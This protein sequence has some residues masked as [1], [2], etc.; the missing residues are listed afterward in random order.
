M[1]GC[2]SPSSTILSAV[3]NPIPAKPIITS[4]SPICEGATLT[5]TT[6]NVTGGTFS[7]TGVNSFSTSVQNPSIA[8]ITTA[9]S[10]DY[11]ATVTVDGCTSAASD[12]ISVVVNAK[13]TITASANKTSIC[14]GESVTLT[15]SGAGSSGTYAWDDGSTS[16]LIS[17]S[18][19]SS[20]T[21]SV[22][23]TD[24]NGCT[25]SS[26]VSITVNAIP[27][28]TII[29]NAVCAGNPLS[30]AVT[31]A[32]GGI[33]DYNYIWTVPAGAVAQGSVSSFSTTVPGIYTG[34][35]KDKNTEC[36]SINQTVTATFYP[37]PSAAA[38][39]ASDNKVMEGETLNLTAAASGGTGAYTYTWVPNATTN[40]TITGGENALFN[41][42]KEGIVNIKYQVKDANNCLT[43]SADLAITIAP[44]V[45]IFDLPNA[46]TPNGDGKNDVLKL[47]TNA[48]VTEL[49]SF[50]IFSRSGNLVFESRDVSRGWDGRY[51]GNL[52]PIDIYYWTAV[53]VDR[54]NV[55]NSKTGTVLLL[56]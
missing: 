24:A 55:T 37:L 9:A 53:Y 36:E 32:T 46:F 38:I 13:P 35:I 20:K 50:K 3:V 43:Q 31:P 27:S 6:S 26:A 23:G 29:G 41:A 7:W 49:R 18:T 19:S 33:A 2:T 14:A 11:T 16:N 21:Y 44:A 52:L 48:G 10:G 47:I 42:I 4:N 8:A 56:K 45:I 54:N 25:N 39:V 5:L 34:K 17:L 28:F 40:Y 51:N 1:N 22:T 15:A 12:L 30:I